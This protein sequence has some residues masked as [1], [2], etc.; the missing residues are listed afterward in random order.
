MVHSS[1]YKCQFMADQ[2]KLCLVIVF[3][4][5]PCAGKRCR[6][7]TDKAKLLKDA[8]RHRIQALF[9]LT[10]VISAVH[11]VCFSLAL[12]FLRM[13]FGF[14]YFCSSRTCQ[15]KRRRPHSDW[16]FV[17]RCFNIVFFWTIPNIFNLPFSRL[18]GLGSM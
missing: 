17:V 8:R 14:A 1:P 6:K 16:F 11:F 4:S 9:M 10:S 2:R 15:K 13:G 7:L 12:L 5:Y 18:S 3:V